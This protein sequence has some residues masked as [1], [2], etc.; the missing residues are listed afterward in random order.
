VREPVS[1]S[2]FAGYLFG[3]LL[4]IVAA[5]IAWRFGIDAERKSLETI[6]RPLAIAD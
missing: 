2:V 1:T 5:A 4:M 3:S 6:A